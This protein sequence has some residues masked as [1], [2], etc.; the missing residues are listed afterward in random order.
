M[1]H[2]EMGYAGATRFIE[3]NGQLSAETRY[4]HRDA[5]G[6]GDEYARGWRDKI[7][8]ARKACGLNSFS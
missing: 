6:Y 7:N 8:E 5:H 3:A 4:I 1:T 2:Y